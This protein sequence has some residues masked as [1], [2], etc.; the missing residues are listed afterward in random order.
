M[1]FDPS[2]TKDWK[3][4]E[5]NML[6]N[7]NIDT[8]C[9]YV[10]KTLTKETMTTPTKVSFNILKSCTKI[11]GINTDTTVSHPLRQNSNITVINWKKWKEDG[12][13]KH[14]HI[15]S[16]NCFKTFKEINH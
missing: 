6:Q 14:C 7:L 8:K 4:I 1:L 11:L 3:Y 9:L 13:T 5:K 2:V 10:M 12:V 16:N 15:F